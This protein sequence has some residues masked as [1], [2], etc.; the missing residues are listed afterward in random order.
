MNGIHLNLPPCPFDIHLHRHTLDGEVHAPGNRDLEVHRPGEAHPPLRAHLD[1][2]GAAPAVDLDVP[3]AG[4]IG[5][6]L[7]RVP[8]PGADDHLPPETLQ[9]EPGGPVGGNNGVG[10]GDQGC[11]AQGANNDRSEHG[12]PLVR[13]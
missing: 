10:L 6:D 1:M 11:S 12:L 8:I 4:V 2:D 7:D 9:G 13:L 5:L 3:G